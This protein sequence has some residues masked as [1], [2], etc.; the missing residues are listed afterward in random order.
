MSNDLGTA[1]AAL[2]RS[3]AEVERKANTLRSAINTL[4]EEAGIPPK[5]PNVGQSA[6]HAA[7]NTQ[8]QPDTFYGKKQSTAIRMYLEMRKAQGLGPATPRDIFEAL[9]T[10]GYQFETRNEINALVGMRALLRKNTVTF[11]KLPN[12][13]YGL[14]T[15]YPDA[16]AGRPSDDDDEEEAAPNKEATTNRKSAAASELRKAREPGKRG[17]PPKAPERKEKPDVDHRPDL[18]GPV[19]GTKVA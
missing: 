9:K 1:I 13:S 19:T 5:Y 8:I 14:L 15:W 17:R 11:H 7:V 18:T 2:E 4:C 3:L 16:K 6:E 10:G 12:G